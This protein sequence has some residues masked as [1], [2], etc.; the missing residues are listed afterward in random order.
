MA[1]A[2]AAG[3]AVSRSVTAAS[4]GVRF[5][6]RSPLPSVSLRERALLLKQVG[7]DGI[8][9]GNEWMAK[10]LEFLQ[11]EL[12]G[13]VA[14]SA[15][16]GSIEL[17]HIDAEKRSKAIE[18]DRRRLETATALKADCLIEVP[19]FGPS[20]FPDLSPLMNAREVEERLLMAGLKQL[21]GDIERSGVTLLLEPC[22]HKETPFMYRQS[23]A[24]RVIEGVG[25]PAIGILSDF[26]HMQLEEPNIAAT[27]AQ[28]GRYTRYVHLADGEKRLEPG[29][30][31]FDYRPGFRELK[32]WGYAGWLTIESKATDRPEAALPRALKYLKQQWAE[33]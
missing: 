27:L 13:T 15:I 6:V 20:R 23:Q 25:S 22:N 8:E 12:D 33:A 11:K 28:Y 4:R 5:G 21:A 16:V 31:P 7:F 14:V 1:G 18:T 2:V 29:S 19:T 10:P 30:L 9:L 17:L 24:A 26:Y 32:K 3:G